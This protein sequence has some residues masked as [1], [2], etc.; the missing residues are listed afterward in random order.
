MSDSRLPS[1]DQCQEILLKYKT[2]INVIKHCLA[3]AKISEEFCDK[4]NDID[5]KLVVAGA[6]LHDI[7]R[8]I[9]H[10]IKHAIVG[11]KILEKENLD[12]RIISI[13]KRHI[14][15]GITEEEAIKLGLPVDDYIPRTNE[16]VLVSYADNLVCGDKR[17]SFEETL[18]RFINKF[19]KDS[20]VVKGFYRQKMIIEKM[21]D[22]N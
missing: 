11:A 18:K 14:G 13:V 20:H 9:D 1:K 16:E 6:M 15:T 2:P 7:G 5:K 12:P 4:I 3:V 17:C 22:S 8:S 19:G 21:L 10:S